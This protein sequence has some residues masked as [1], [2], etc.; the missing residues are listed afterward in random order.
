MN[1]IIK[2]CLAFCGTIFVGAIGSGVWEKLLSPMLS[3][4]LGAITYVLSII[5]STYEDS[6]YQNASTVSYE[7]QSGVMFLFGMTFLG[8]ACIFSSSKSLEHIAIAKFANMV[9]SSYIKGWSGLVIGFSLFVFSTF[10]LSKQTS[11]FK[12]RQYSVKSMHIVRP[13][14]G[15][16]SYYKLYSEYLL[17]KDKNDFDNFLKKIE[18]YDSNYKIGMEPFSLK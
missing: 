1:K 5:S 16:Q 10:L 9:L 6:I 14:I 17:V 8:L 7:G 15:E 4:L 11:V 3:Y 18:E 13:Y 2:I 12:V